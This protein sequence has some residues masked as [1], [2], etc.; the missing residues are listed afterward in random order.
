M[1]SELRPIR[2]HSV[3]R[4]PPH[5]IEA[6]QSVLGGILFDNQALSRALEQIKT[7]EEFYKPAHRIIY[8]AFLDLFEKG[9]PIDMMTVNETLK[10]NKKISEAGGL[11]YLAELMDIFPT[12]AN[13]GIHAK[14]VKEKA[15]LR[16]LIT[17]AGEL[18]NLGF[19]D[20]ESVDEVI[21][22]AEQMIF[23]LAEDRLERG[24]ADLKELIHDTNE[25]LDQLAS[26]KELV[27][28]I[29]TGFKKLDEMT[30]GFQGGELIVLAGRPSM[31]KT[32]LSINITENV[33]IDSDKVVA[34]F[35][36]EMSAMQL[37]IR[38]LS[39]ISKVAMHKI[40]TGFLSASDWTSIRSA[41]ER[42][43]ES[44]IH[45]DDAPMQTVLD[46]RSKAR[47]LKAEKGLDMIVIDYLQLLHSRGRSENR[48][49]EIGEMTRS[50]KGLAREMDVPV[51]LLSQ[52]SRKVEDR[53]NKKPQLADLRESGTIEQDADVV[54]FVYREEYYY[55]DKVEVQNQAEV[56]IGKQ[57][58][59]P[60]GRAKMIFLKE[61]ARFENLAFGVPDF[62]GDEDED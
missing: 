61:N 10:K 58:N 7:G 19:E 1:A 37:I 45:I 53:P 36:L 62:G 27:T 3:G 14:I 43:Y 32:A 42:L 28:G 5:N 34:F 8:S 41:S 35:S 44:N 52:L 22:R 17:T 55:P 26:R 46:I 48:V 57:R 21:D 38:M 47:R 54:A 12:S 56:I 25:H 29:A 24:F 40:R 4:V 30:A 59:G 51:L 20:S 39:S 33:S 49:L 16:R 60:T 23:E 9:D 18:V 31:G 50:L 15:L 6:E 13:V 2:E 11:D